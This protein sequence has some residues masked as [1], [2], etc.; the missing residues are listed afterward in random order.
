EPKVVPSPFGGKKTQPSQ[1]LIIPKK[2]AVPP[3]VV[4]TAPAKKAGK[5]AS[6]SF[7]K[8]KTETD[9][10]AQSQAQQPAQKQVQQPTQLQ[11]QQQVQQQTHEP[12]Q[13]P[14]QQP[15]AKPAPK[16]NSS[17]SDDEGDLTVHTVKKGETMQSI[18]RFYGVTVEQILK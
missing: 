1:S 2:E 4:E 15:A 18:A 3:P 16:S 12:A 10:S 5:Q 14:A 7:L 6:P 13:Q 9:R 17:S 11:T 8:P